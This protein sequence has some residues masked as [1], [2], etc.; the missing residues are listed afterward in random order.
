[1]NLTRKAVS[2]LAVL[3]LVVAAA[4]AQTS[5]QD[6]AA[7][8]SSSSP[9]S[10]TSPGAVTGPGTTSTGTGSPGSGAMGSGSGGTTI[11]SEVTF[12]QLDTNRDGAISV[13]EADAAPALAR[14]F[15]SLDANRDGKLTPA[16]FADWK[17]R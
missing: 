7:P 15:S 13:T 12:E 4:H 5:T 3:G 9:A 2:A 10:P 8:P 16:E 1:M 14:G 11:G 17:Q 6:K